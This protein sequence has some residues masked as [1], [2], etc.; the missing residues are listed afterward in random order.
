MQKEK[1]MENHA[2]H[3]I[4]GF[5]LT[6]HALNILKHYELTP[7]AINVLLY[8]TS[9]YNPKVGYVFPKQKTIAATFN[10][11]ERSVI[12]AIQNLVKAGLIIV[13]CKT[14]NRYR[15]TSKILNEEA[16]NKKEMSHED[17]K[18]SS[19]GDK[20]S[21][22]EHEQIKEE[23]KKQEVIVKNSNKKEPE[24]VEDYKILKEYAISQGVTS[25]KIP[26]YIAGIK[27]RGGEAGI[28]KKAKEKRAA[29]KFFEKQIAETIENNRKVREGIEDAIMPWESEAMRN[30]LKTLRR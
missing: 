5:E 16:L 15:F 2:A 9:C 24:S 10:I 21:S 13:E 8:L 4:S 1:N 26:A 17:E 28:L 14:I 11:T 25:D 19:L 29:D 20:M 22:H 12:R 23:I 18:I 7:T 6:K 3:A 30:V 27:R